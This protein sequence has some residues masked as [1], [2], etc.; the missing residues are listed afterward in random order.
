VNAIVSWPVAR[1]T[2][3]SRLRSVGPWIVGVIFAATAALPTGPDASGAESFRGPSAIWFVV[4]TFTLGTA[5]LS[6]E[7]ESGHAQLVLLRPLTR[8]AWFGGRL[9]GACVALALFCALAWLASIA[10]AAA[11]GYGFR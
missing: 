3:K 11:R 5:M 10:S 4:L 9:A 6:E 8:A 2:F 7:I 1:A